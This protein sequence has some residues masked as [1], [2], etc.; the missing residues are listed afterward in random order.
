MEEFL[1]ENTIRYQ[2][3]LISSPVL[4]ETRVAY[5]NPRWQR[6]DWGFTQPAE[7]KRFR[8]EV[9]PLRGCLHEKTR[10]SASFI[11]G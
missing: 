1:N 3:T 11:P 10:T 4:L 8:L 2:P 5:E 6:W 9:Q 7:L